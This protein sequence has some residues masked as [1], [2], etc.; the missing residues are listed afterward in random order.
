MQEG[1]GREHSSPRAILFLDVLLVLHLPPNGPVALP[2]RF[3]EDGW[4]ATLALVRANV[5]LQVVAPGGLVVAA[6]EG[7]GHLNYKT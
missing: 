3:L 1:K 5:L 6:F 7:T 4:S 2:P